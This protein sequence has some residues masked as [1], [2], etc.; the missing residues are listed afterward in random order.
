MRKRG[1]IGG[2]TNMVTAADAG[3]TFRG[4]TKGM[5]KLERAQT[6]QT[7]ERKNILRKLD[8]FASQ[9]RNFTPRL[10]KGER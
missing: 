9:P 2:A 8:A 3:I 5:R 7:I 4:T 1:S 10:V 6:A